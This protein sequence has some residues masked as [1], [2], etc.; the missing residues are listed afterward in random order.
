M[1]AICCFFSPLLSAAGA[2]VYLVWLSA[3]VAHLT[4][5]KPCSTADQLAC[6]HL[7]WWSCLLP[8]NLQF[9]PVLAIGML[10]INSW[11]FSCCPLLLSRLLACWNLILFSPV[12][13][14][15]LAIQLPT[16]HCIPPVFLLLCLLDVTIENTS[17]ESLLKTSLALSMSEYSVGSLDYCQWPPLVVCDL[18]LA[19]LIAGISMFLLQP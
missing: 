8:L 16:N 4:S 9:L 12:V 2:R 1:L 5:Q 18:L 19:S 10:A 11:N 15:S 6:P 13:F 7:F 3:V 14:R 17:L